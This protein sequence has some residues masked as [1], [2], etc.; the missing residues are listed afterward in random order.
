MKKFLLSALGLFTT[1]CI[2]IP[3]TAPLKSLTPSG[4]AIDSVPKDGTII[5]YSYV[6]KDNLKKGTLLLDTPVNRVAVNNY[7]KAS[8]FKT[9]RVFK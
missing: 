5:A 3:Y 7:L 8:T 6:P 9:L 1:A 4:H 2:T